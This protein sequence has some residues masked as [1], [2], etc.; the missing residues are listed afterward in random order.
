MASGKQ[1]AR[2][3]YEVLAGRSISPND[4]ELHWAV[5][6]YSREPGYEKRPRVSIRTTSPA[7]RLLSQAAPVEL[8]LSREE[9]RLEAGRC[10]DCGINTIFD[11]DRCILCGGCVDVCPEL[12]LRIVSVDRLSGEGEVGRVLSGQLSDAR[13]EDASAILKEETICIRCGLCAERCP[14]EAITMERFQFKEV[15]TCQVV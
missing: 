5:P 8:C 10:L 15:P 4:V 9:A 6:D 1:V 3:V 13:P 2:S 11:G 7:E 12:C 14:T